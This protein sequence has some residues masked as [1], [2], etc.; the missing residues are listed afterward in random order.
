MTDLLANLKDLAPIGAV[1]VFA[2]G[3]YQF[4]RSIELSFRK[5][6]WEKLLALYIDAC[7]NAAM[8]ART[9]VE[10]EWYAARNSFWKLYYGPLCLV[11][12]QKVEQ[13]MINFNDALGE[14]SF[15]SK[16]TKLLSDLSLELAFACRNSIGTDWRVPLEE[17][18]GQKGHS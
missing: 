9:D 18:T 15:S 1:I 4:Y 11:E 14:S 5:P 13:A 17:L 2:W 12:D 16:N 10:A 8:L 7:S 3:V 6:Y